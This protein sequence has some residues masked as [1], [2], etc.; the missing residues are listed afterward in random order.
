[1][2]LRYRCA[3]HCFYN[4]QKG[5]GIRVWILQYASCVGMRLHSGAQDK[6][7]SGLKSS[8]G[9]TARP[10]LKI[11][12]QP[13]RRVLMSYWCRGLRST[14]YCVESMTSTNR[15]I[16]C[17]GWRCGLAVR[18]WRY[19]WSPGL[20]PRCPKNQLSGTSST[21][22]VKAGGSTIQSHPWPA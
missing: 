11:G 3:V 15:N 20:K 19:A 21:Q 5:F 22:D 7:I 10:C 12:M 13:Q 18:V 8:L 1:M 16:V 14:H 9:Y 17:G 4:R 2:P 6:R